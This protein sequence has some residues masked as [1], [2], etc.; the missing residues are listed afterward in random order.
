MIRAIVCN[1]MVTPYTNRLFNYIV[2]CNAVDLHVVSCALREANRNW[3]GDYAKK[4]DH[5][6]L[7]G[8]QRKL[9]GARIIHFNIGIW[10]AL[11]RLKPQVVAINGIYPTMLI[12]VLWSIIHRVPLIFLS[13]GWRLTMPMSIF[14]RMV[15]PFILGRCR[16]IICASEKGRRFFVEE[17]VDPEHIFVAHIAPAWTA[18]AE[19][20]DFDRRPY[21]L[22]WCGRLDDPAK[23]PEFFVRIAVLLKKRFCDLRIRVIGDGVLRQNTL[24]EL[25]H[26]GINVDYTDYIAPEKMAEAFT[27][28]RILVMPSTKEPWGLVCNE[29]MQCGVPC[30]V[31]PFTGVAEELVVNGQSGFVLDLEKN[32]WADTISSV[33][34]DR[35]TWTAMSKAAIESAGKY[36]MKSFG[37]S[38]ID[39]LLFAGRGIET[40]S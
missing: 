35:T 22:L 13:D 24:D 38:Y 29:A 4:Y 7:K 31:S 27:A 18:P 8:F 1:N 25:S 28:S 14:H 21:H 23:N 26:A 30:V 10:R 17:G 32:L 11:S 3:S 15:R 34:S 19:L 5:V 39:G 36:D 6:I 37:K 33:I 12:A 40:R 2:D 20:P 16:A 9:N